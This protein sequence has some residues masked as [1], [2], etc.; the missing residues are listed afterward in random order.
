VLHIGSTRRVAGIE[1]VFGSHYYPNIQA[2][3]NYL[4]SVKPVKK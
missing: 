1:N 4:K 3:N 2:A